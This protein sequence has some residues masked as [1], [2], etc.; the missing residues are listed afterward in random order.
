MPC[1]FG[2]LRYSGS[3]AC[4]KHHGSLEVTVTVRYLPLVTAAYGTLV[5][6]PPRTAS[7]HGEATLP[8]RPGVRPVL[9]TSVSWA[10][11]ECGAAALPVGSRTPCGAAVLRDQG[12]IGRPARQG[13]SGLDPCIGI[14]RDDSAVARSAQFVVW[15][16]VCENVSGWPTVFQALPAVLP[17]T[18]NTPFLQNWLLNELLPECL[19]QLVPNEL[20]GSCAGWP[21]CS[22]R[23]LCWLG[24]PARRWPRTPARIVPTPRSRP[25][26]CRG[27]GWPRDRCWWPWSPVRLWPLRPAP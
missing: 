22:S 20:V 9:G 2:R 6:R 3:A 26:L 21:S 7:S 23:R 18:A 17:P 1:S 25:S 4:A 27:R 8:A 5:A 24:R 10:N 13:R 11:R 14:R 12:P 19:S 15:I 16:G